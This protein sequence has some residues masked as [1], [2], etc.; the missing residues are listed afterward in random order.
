MARLITVWLSGLL[1]CFGTPAGA[2]PLVDLAGREVVVPERVERIILGEGR[3]LPALAI[4]EGER[5]A[6]RLVGMPQDFKGVDPAGY[7][8]YLDAVPALAQVPVIGQGSADS[9]SLE[10]VLT[11]RPDLAIFSLAG[12]GPDSSHARLIGQLQQAGVAVLFVDFREQPLRNT[13]RSIELLGRALDRESRATAFVQRYRDALA[14]VTERLPEG[15]RPGVFIH[16]RAGLS[17]ACC[18]SMA[19]GMFADLL[20]AAGAT[21]VAVDLLP[22]A[23]GVVNPEWLL[24]HPPRH[25]IASAIGASGRDE[26]EG[27]VMLGPMVGAAA[28]E[29]SLQSLTLRYSLP[30]LAAIREGRAHGIWH[31]FYNSP[32][33]VVAVQVFATWLYPEH[34]ADLDPRQTLAEFYRDFQ[35]VPLDGT[36]WISL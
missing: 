13:P 19:R 6:D 4:L 9:F 25:Y 8:Q 28:A 12:H 5:L 14:R 24:S 30:V 22:G 1:A 2:A 23:T 35:P 27:Y 26:A 17:D 15:P 32:F 33:N 21:N 10:Q 31:S 20:D 29:R 11:L 3:L 18:E 34:F 7:Q 36:Y 16:S